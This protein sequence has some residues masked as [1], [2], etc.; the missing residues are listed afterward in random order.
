MAR[1]HRHLAGTASSSPSRQTRDTTD[2]NREKRRAHA[3]PYR[4]PP[5]SNRLQ[6]RWRCGCCSIATVIRRHDD[7]IILVRGASKCVLFHRT[8]KKKKSPLLRVSRDFLSLAH[9]PIADFY[10]SFRRIRRYCCYRHSRGPA[11][12]LLSRNRQNLRDTYVYCTRIYNISAAVKRIYTNKKVSSFIK[13]KKM[14]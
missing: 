11:Y 10:S 13:K 9:P 7:V 8:G 4:T 5:Q 2:E 3:T 12:Q 14:S 1:Y 6:R